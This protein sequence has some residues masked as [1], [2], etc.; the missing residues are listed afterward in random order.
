MLRRFPRKQG[1]VSTI[2]HHLRSFSPHRFTHQASFLGE[3]WVTPSPVAQPKSV[4]L[5]QP[6]PFI[7]LPVRSGRC[8]AS[9]Y[10]TVAAAKTGDGAHGKTQEDEQRERR[11][12]QLRA[13]IELHSHHY[14]ALGAPLI[15]DGAFD[16]LVRE[17]QGLLA[18]PSEGDAYDDAAD[19]K[20]LIPAKVG[21]P[22]SSPS[23]E[24]VKHSTPMLSLAAVRNKTELGDWYERLRSRLQSILMANASVSA[25]PAEHSEVTFVLEPKYDGLALSLRYCGN[26]LV[27]AGTRGDGHV[28][29]DVT[30]NLSLIAGIPQELDGHSWP[31]ATHC[32]RSIEVRGEVF[33]TRKDFEALNRHQLER[34]LPTFANPRNAAAGSLRLLDSESESSVR[35]L[36]FI[37]Y[38]VIDDQNVEDESFASHWKAMEA[39]KGLGFATGEHVQK[40]T[41][42]AD[43]LVQ[44]ALL[45]EKRDQLPYEVDG[46]V[47]KVDDRRLQ[48]ALGQSLTDPRWAVAWKFPAL[49]AS[50]QLQDVTFSIGRTGH[51]VPLAVLS[52]VEIGGV[53]VQRAT[54]HNAGMLIKLG[55]RI[56]DQVVLQRAGDVI[57]Q[58]I[59]VV[60][61]F[62]GLEADTVEV[63]V[64]CP[65]C[66]SPLQQRENSSS[67]IDESARDGDGEQLAD[68]SPDAVDEEEKS[69]SE[70]DGQSPFLLFCSNVDA[71]PAQNVRRLEHFASVCFEGVGPGIVQKV[72]DE[73]ALVGNIADFY[74]LQFEDLKDL[75]GF[76]GQ[77]A[78]NI[79]EAIEN[80]KTQSLATVLHGFGIP[81][82]GLVAARQLYEYGHDIHRIR[83]MDEETLLE[84][85]GIGPVLARSITKWFGRAVTQTL[86]ADLEAIGDIQWMKSSVSRPVATSD[87][88]WIGGPGAL[89]GKRVVVSGRWSKMTRR[90]A[91]HYVARHGAKVAKSLGSKVDFL[92]VGERPAESKLRRAAD[93]GVTVLTESMLV[94]MCEASGKESAT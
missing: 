62:R 6:K 72:V 41:T 33:M 28:G 47:L 37:A 40:C 25:P 79:L 59:S 69:G 26:H 54:L 94:D 1:E 71:C 13:A 75:D 70:G 66:G 82:V 31:Q 80:S 57:P 74:R 67:P 52:P 3:R 29:E 20:E 51:L 18:Q 24:K 7:T 4:S 76:G 38:D 91:E 49:E 42:F 23:F 35:R 45:R 55:L 30:R 89:A 32:K 92:V 22:V 44:A 53:I 50:T 36:S 88:N 81:H 58:V 78:R 48:D 56:G 9:R 12:S 87:G 27:L 39:L 19:V 61:G 90:Q 63:P 17:L 60:E 34:G 73:H 11:I 93:L 84:I 16:S 68:S 21:A 14:H 2:M 86:L 8:E 77:S 10:S 64:A 46:V 15:S 65:S 83:E 43:A 5:L 85:K